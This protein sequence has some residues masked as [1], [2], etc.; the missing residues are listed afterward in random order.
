MKQFEAIFVL[1]P[2]SDRGASEV[3]L[4]YYESKVAFKTPCIKR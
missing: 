4:G 1:G 3:F 2:K